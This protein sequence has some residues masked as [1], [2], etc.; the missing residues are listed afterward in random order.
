[1]FNKEIVK[2]ASSCRHYA[3]CKIDFLE[4]GI[5]HSAIGGNFVGFYPQGRMDIYDNLA[6]GNVGVTEG[7]V[8]I[9]ESC[10][11]CGVCDKQCHFVT[12]L[13]PV[14]VMK[15]L[16]KYVEDYKKSGKEI[17]KTKSDRFL[18]DL[19]NIVGEQW[20]TND[21]AHLI[22]YANDPSPLTPLTTPKY[23]AA[24][25][26]KEEIQKIVKL[27]ADYQIKYN[28]RGNG[29]SVMGFV[30]S[31]G[32]VIDVNR[33]KDIKIDKDNWKVFVEPGVTAFD[34]QKK[35][36]SEGYRVN[37]AEPSAL[38]CA[39]I[40]CSGIFSNFSY[41]YGTLADNYIDAEFIDSKGELFE[42]ND[43]NSPNLYSY[44]K[45]EF[46]LPGI[47]AGLSMKLQPIAKDEE[48]ILIPFDNFKEA[49]EFSRDLAQRRLG[50]GLGIL[51]GEYLSTFISPT[52]EIAKLTKDI[53]YDKL[54]IKYLV[55]FIG[56]KYSVE[57]VKKI[58]VNFIDN[59]LLKILIL[60]LPKLASEDFIEIIDN[61]SK[62]KIYSLLTDKKIRPLLKAALSSTPESF[63]KSVPADLQ[64]FYEKLYSRPELTDLVWVSMFRILSS[65]MGR[66][67][68]VVAFIV[69]IPMNNTE[70][71]QSMDDDFRAVADEFGI[72]NDFGFIT[73][74][75]YGKRAVY[76]YDYYIDHTDADEIEKCR[77]AIFKAGAMIEGYS[78]KYIGVKWIR[79]TLHQGF[80]RSENLLYT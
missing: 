3:M 31:E 14:A 70:M 9:A 4:T 53:F 7:L 43:K 47:C 77:A 62:D 23:I 74:L 46:P 49:I 75:D 48:G 42:L 51:G 12:E 69:Y 13:R 33:M 55:L 6:K 16:K 20:A 17:I 41:A 72:K 61:F 22:C 58:S 18:D 66:E 78:A 27:C 65:R 35:V 54:N 68:H 64:K 80:C 10:N 38:V 63:S 15:E 45:G 67:K 52:V 57:I 21:P 59:E 1:M 50:V 56:D 28:I 76:E 39:N 8:N 29:S 30:M 44:K 25:R 40:M 36:Y 79:Y 32:V 60:G 19:K 5:C 11:L 2:I 37:V 24:P 73:P 26:T 71:I 34:L